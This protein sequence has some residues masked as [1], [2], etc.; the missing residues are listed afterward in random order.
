MKGGRG[1][2]RPP[3]PKEQKE[4][5]AAPAHHHPS[6]RLDFEMVVSRRLRVRSKGWKPVAGT[7]GNRMRRFEVHSKGAKPDAGT[8]A[9]KLNEPEASM[10]P[11]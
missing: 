5:G 11:P 3:P 8:R 7:R 9:L 1:R 10:A 6:L 4:G 2:T